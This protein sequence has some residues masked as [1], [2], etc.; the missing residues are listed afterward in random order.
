M[1][2]LHVKH[3]CRGQMFVGGKS[4]TEVIVT[5]DLMPV[6]RTGQEVR[7][8]RWGLESERWAGQG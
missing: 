7:W 6:C 4:E 2:F 3:L 8:I 5:D 1:G